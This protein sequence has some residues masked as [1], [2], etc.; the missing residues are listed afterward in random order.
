MSNHYLWQHIIRALIMFTFFAIHLVMLKNTLVLRK[1][2]K[3]VFLT[4]I[5]QD[6]FLQ[7]HLPMLKGQSQQRFGQH[8]WTSFI[9]KRNGDFRCLLGSIPL[10]FNIHETFPLEKKLFRLLNVLHTK[11]VVTFTIFQQIVVR[12]RSNFN[13]NQRNLESYR[14]R[15]SHRI[16]VC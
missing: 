6:S 16:E 14:R 13:R 3:N 2:Y 9:L 11:S 1:N 10:S 12:K 4:E 8:N 15:T 5:T 7:M